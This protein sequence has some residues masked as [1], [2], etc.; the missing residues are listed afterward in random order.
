M[1]RRSNRSTRSRRGPGRPSQP[2]ETTDQLEVL[3][4]GQELVEPGVLA[5]DPDAAADL[6]RPGQRVDAVDDD[7]A[8]VGADQGG[9]DPDQGG[10]AGAVAAQHPQRRA[11]RDAQ[12][13]AVQCARVAPSATS[14]PSTTTASA[15][16]VTPPR[17]AGAARPGVADDV[18][19][20]VRPRP[21]LG[22]GS[23]ARTV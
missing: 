19:Q 14:T 22:A 20:H 18:V 9:Q 23:S 13:D 16:H 17:S 4:G 21:R 3:G 7:T 5:G 12:V 2:G 1:P 6:G 11:W 10:L 8:A 15:G